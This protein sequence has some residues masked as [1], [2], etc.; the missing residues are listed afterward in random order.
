MAVVRKRRES[1]GRRKRSG[2]REPQRAELDLSSESPV[3]SGE[4]GEDESPVLESDLPKV[5]HVVRMNHRELMRFAFT[6]SGFPYRLEF[7]SLPEEVQDR[8]VEMVDSGATYDEA[9]KWLKSKGF[10]VSRYSVQRY[11]SLLRATRSDVERGAA[12]QLM[13]ARYGEMDPLTA[14]QSAIN[15]AHA[16]CLRM[17]A[18]DEV[19][20]NMMPELLDKLTRSLAVLMKKKEMESHVRRNVKRAVILCDDVKKREIKRLAYGITE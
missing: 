7:L 3:G 9:A 18:M 13:Q 17:L 1:G 19:P 15:L 16:Q 20:I 6:E 2:R 12:L 8:V 11:Y 10:S 4:V 14:L 5:P